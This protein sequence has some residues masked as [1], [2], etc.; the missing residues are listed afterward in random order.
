M[1]LWYNVGIDGLLKFRTYQLYNFRNSELQNFGTEKLLD[2][3]ISEPRNFRDII[4][5]VW[6]IVVSQPASVKPGS[7]GYRLVVLFIIITVNYQT[8]C[9]LAWHPS[10]VVMG[11]LVD[12]LRKRTWASLVQCS[13][14][15]GVALHCA[16]I[17]ST[18]WPLLD[19]IPSAFCPHSVCIP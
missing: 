13:N 7:T 10:A 9:P 8:A 4:R 5:K 19:C 11:L 2:F 15:P 18:F 1:Y 6:I 17:V 12:R 16:C 14:L 3:R